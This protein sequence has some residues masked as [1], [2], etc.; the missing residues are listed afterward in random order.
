M[1]S[2]RSGPASIQGIPLN[3]LYEA[4]TQFQREFETMYATGKQPKEFWSD[5]F[6]RIADKGYIS[7]R[8]LQDSIYST[9]VPYSQIVC[10]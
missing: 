10:C 9:F 2:K 1:S 4:V 3:A 7:C 6:I 5:N 8:R